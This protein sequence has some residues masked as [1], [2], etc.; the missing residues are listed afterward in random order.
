MT[1]D[2][3]APVGSKA[4]AEIDNLRKVGDP[5]LQVLAGGTAQRGSEAVEEEQEEE[6]ETVHEGCE[7][8]KTLLL[9]VSRQAQRHQSLPTQADCQ[10]SEMAFV[11]RTSAEK[12]LPVDRC[13]ENGTGAL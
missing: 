8:A 1:W 2:L 9:Q 5:S 6:T 3:C 12:Y 4:T 10:G 11:D 13:A 7:F